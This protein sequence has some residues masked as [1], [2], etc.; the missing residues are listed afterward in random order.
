MLVNSC[1]VSGGTGVGKVSNVKSDLQVYRQQCHSIGHIRFP[2][3]VPLEICHY[4]AQLTRYYHLF[5]LG[6]SII[7]MMH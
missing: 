3:S 2:I 7:I 1:H 5:P 4:L 6:G